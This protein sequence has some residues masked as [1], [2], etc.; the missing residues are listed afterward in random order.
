MAPAEQVC[1]TSGTSER[2][3]PATITRVNDAEL[4]EADQVLKMTTAHLVRWTTCY[5]ISAAFWTSVVLVS[6]LALAALGIHSGTVARSAFALPDVRHDSAH[7][8][9]RLR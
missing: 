9:D 4:V 8:D 7:L 2:L 6:R 5:G 3:G 1:T